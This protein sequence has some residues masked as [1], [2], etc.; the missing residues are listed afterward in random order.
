MIN[1][2]DKKWPILDFWYLIIVFIFPW[3]FVLACLVSDSLLLI[4]MLLA[5]FVPIISAL[6][7]AR[8]LARDN[9]KAYDMAKMNMII[10]LNYVPVYVLSVVMAVSNGILTILFLGILILMFDMF[11]SVSTGLWTVSCMTKLT[12]E[13]KI[14]T[15]KAILYSIPQFIC[16]LDVIMAIILFV[17][18]RKTE[19]I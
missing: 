6:M 18:V 2:S 7:G 16:Y 3:I 17:R 13:G 5:N 8:G 4:I 12:R 11:C 10:K 9:V 1:N 14:E 15:N 19:N